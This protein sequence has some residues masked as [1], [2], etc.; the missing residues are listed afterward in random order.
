MPIAP[1]DVG[2][3]E[4]LLPDAADRLFDQ[5]I[6]FKLDRVDQ[7]RR[8]PVKASLIQH[9]LAERCF[10]ATA[11]QDEK[12]ENHGWNKAAHHMITLCLSET[13]VNK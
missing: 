3:S 6:P 8:H 4:A 7:I 2:D 10:R 11:G 5:L 9:G 13:A 1:R 12:P